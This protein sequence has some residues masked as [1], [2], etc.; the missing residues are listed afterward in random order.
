MD[1]GGKAQLTDG[2]ATARTRATMHTFALVFTCFLYS[3]AGYLSWV[4]HLTDFVQPN[5]VDL[6]TMVVGYLCQASG[7]FGF[8]VAVQREAAVERR[9]VP[10]ATLVISFM[11]L[12]PAL[13]GT[14]LAGVLT[15]GF[16]FNVLIGFLAG[17]YLHCLARNVPARL[18]ATVFG[19]AYG[20]TTI[21]VWL[22]SFPESGSF[23]RNPAILLV[24]ALLSVATIAAVMASVS[25]GKGSE[26]EK[27]SD[28]TAGSPYRLERPTESILAASSKTDAGFRK[29]LGLACATVILLSL[30]KNLGFSFPISDVQSGLDLELSR[31]AYAVGLIIAGIVSDRSRKYG[32]LLCLISLVS[33]FIMLALAGEPISSMVFWC[34]DYFFFGFFAV[35]RTVLFT[36]IAEEHA[37]YYLAGAGLLCGRIGDALGTAL[38]IWLIGHTL[39]LVITTAVL[40]AIAVALFVLLFQQ[41]FMPQPQ[42]TTSERELFER[43][44]KRYDLSAREREVLR[45]IIKEKTNSEIAATLFVSE[46]TVK[47]HVRNL[48]KKTGCKNRLEIIAKYTEIS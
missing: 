39:A 19:G 9:P 12:V 45:L 42:P 43:F 14:N 21:A 37:M 8:A 3:S 15:F 35:F 6:L 31:I 41:L 27:A 20:T 48:L 16:L 10:I 32:A 36:D 24:Y 30:V 28:E 46:S 7:L 34:M 2:R 38:C 29:F 18:R 40:F 22:L 47:F 23:L 13:L 4:Y 5:H 17:H 26:T 44:C 1:D 33:P 25:S 11:C